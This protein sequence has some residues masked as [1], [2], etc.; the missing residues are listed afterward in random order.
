MK[1]ARFTFSLAAAFVSLTGL[2]TAARAQGPSA[3]DVGARDVAALREEVARLRE[4]VGALRAVLGEIRQVAEASAAS[5][6][7]RPA[8]GGQAGAQQA[9]QV[10]PEMLEMVRAQIAEHAQVKVESASRQAVKLSGT[11]LAN[12]FFNSGEANWLENPNLI[13]ADPPASLDGGSMSATAR[14]SRVGI[15]VAGIAV[16]GWQASGTIVA[17]FLGGVPNFQTGTVMGLPRVLYAF[18]RIEKDDTAIV[19]GQDHVILAPRDPTSL[20]AMSFPLFF[21]SGNLYLRAPQVRV[22]QRL[23][24]HIT[25]AGGVVAPIAGDFGS[26]YEFAPAA[27]A[28]ERS[29][30]PALQGRLAFGTAHPESDGFNVGASAHVGRQQRASGA[31]DRAWVVAVDADVRAGRLGAS[32]EWFSGRDAQPFGGGL[33]RTGRATGGW[34][35][36]RFAATPRVSINGGAG[37]DRSRDTLGGRT[38]LDNR[39]AF[40][41]LI[42]WLTPEVGVSGEY[43]YLRTRLDFAAPTR[44]NH[45]FNF[46]FA[47]KF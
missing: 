34:F 36:A 43:R 41:N 29:R 37:F 15:E 19:A 26:T 42:L 8:G 45:H 20:A 30:T 1:S 11:I 27:G 24:A 32:G 6:G 31:V 4:E 21:R 40:G 14:Q 38:R 39:G 12:T 10:T 46:A 3:A 23:G 13:S 2:A 47:V 5:R 35:E 18:G 9:Q 7:G 33:S 25:V 16:G 17:D 44:D 22:E 28:G